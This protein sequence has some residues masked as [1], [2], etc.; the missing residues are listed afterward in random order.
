MSHLT[1][2][3]VTPCPAAPSR[4]RKH[5]R[6]EAVR[7]AAPGAV[8]HLLTAIPKTINPRTFARDFEPINRLA[9]SRRAARSR[10]WR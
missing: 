10:S 2:T 4:S 3:S 5:A 6:Q 1:V 8:V 7:R 9:P